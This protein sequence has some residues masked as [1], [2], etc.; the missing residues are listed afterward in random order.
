[1]YINVD[2][3]DSEEGKYCPI[4]SNHSHREVEVQ[5]EEQDLSQLYNK[6]MHDKIEPRPRDAYTQQEEEPQ[7]NPSEQPIVNYQE[8][9]IHDASS[10]KSKKGFETNLQYIRLFYIKFCEFFRQVAAYRE[11]VVENLS[12]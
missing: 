8:F 7:P 2:E 10:V 9:Q 5:L 1:L 11:E 4:L 6:A 3:I 12:E